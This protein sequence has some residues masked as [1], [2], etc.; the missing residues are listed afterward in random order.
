MTKLTAKDAFGDPFDPSLS[1]PMPNVKLPGGFDVTLRTMFKDQFCQ[2]RYGL[3]GDN[4]YPISKQGRSNIC[5]SLRWIS[6]EKK[7]NKTWMKIGKKELLFVY[8]SKLPKIDGSFVTSF[9]QSD[10][11]KQSFES[12]AKEFLKYLQQV[13]K[14]EPEYY[15]ETIQLFILRKLDKART[16]VVY[17]RNVSPNDIVDN[18]RQWLQANNNLPDFP[19]IFN[20][21]STLYPLDVSGL[22][23]KIWA[24]DTQTAGNKI[25]S[26]Q[27]IPYYHGIELFF[28]VNGSI[29][30]R[31][32]H[33]IVNSTKNLAICSGNFINSFMKVLTKD[34]W[35]SIDGIRETLSLF[36]M[37]L[38]WEN[39][40][41]ES[42]M[43]DVPYLLGQL[44]KV[45]D[46]LHELYSYEV[47]DGKLPPQLAGSGLYAF[48]AE[49][50]VQAISQLGMRMNPY[51]TWAKSNKDARLQKEREQNGEKTTIVGPSAGY[52]L[53][54]YEKT[55]NTLIPALK[56]STRFNDY[57]KAQLFIGYLASFPKSERNSS[58]DVNLHSEN[59]QE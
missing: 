12:E 2:T 6:S 21:F 54:V 48:A 13:K 52:L 4:S 9:G 27:S 19:P 37:F 40:K 43:N 55:A 5:N 38:Y 15:P 8:P 22:L 23:N 36:G 59:M 49:K 51:I 58:T 11:N 18:S 31:S 39:I 34:E 50:P 57:E 33:V 53:Y 32:L 41:K 10:N 1:E 46:S 14:E 7:K 29:R 30:Q 35:K 16:K 45:S 3:I 28:G 24:W 20:S 17:S 25:V 56:P 26:V 42:Y 47:R 44:L